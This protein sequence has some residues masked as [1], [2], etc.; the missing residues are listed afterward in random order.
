[1][2]QSKYLKISR[3]QKALRAHAP[4]RYP[5]R[6]QIS[7]KSIVPVFR[8]Y[9]SIRSSVCGFSNPKMKRKYVGASS[10]C[11][12]CNRSSENNETEETYDPG[13]G[14]SQPRSQEKR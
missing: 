12:R 13:E 10:K 1:M 4:S 2:L 11:A 5:V 3:R 9:V 6:L 7:K 8:Q 14:P